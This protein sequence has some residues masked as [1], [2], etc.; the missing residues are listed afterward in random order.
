MHGHNA[1]M[2]NKRVKTAAERFNYLYSED[3]LREWVPRVRD[4]ASDSQEVHVLMNNC[5]RDYSVRNAKEIG[6][7]LGVFKEGGVRS[8]EP[9]GSDEEQGRLGI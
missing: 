1:E 4:M 2:W 5:H 8:K 9:G 6:E 7:M 3:E